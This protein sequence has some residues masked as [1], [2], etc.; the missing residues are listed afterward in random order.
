M[1]RERKVDGCRHDFR[2]NNPAK[3]R[4]YAVL[5]TVRYS[6]YINSISG[7]AQEIDVIEIAIKMIKR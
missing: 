3:H 2:D 7:H 5:R 1:S 4:W 6:R